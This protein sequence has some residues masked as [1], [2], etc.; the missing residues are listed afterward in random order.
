LATAF[1]LCA[2]AQ[3]LSL[4]EYELPASSTATSSASGGSAGNGGSSGHSSGDAGWGGAG[5][6]VDCTDRLPAQCTVPVPPLGGECPPDCG[7]CPGNKCVKTCDTGDPC[8]N[9]FVCPPGFACEVSCSSLGCTAL[10]V[11]CPE[12]YEC[13]VNC[14]WSDA[15]TGLTLKCSEGGPCELWCQGHEESCDTASVSCGCNSCAVGCET[16]LDITG[17]EPEVSCGT[18][19]ECES[20]DPPQ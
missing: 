5:G 6:A 3:L 18:S 20:C 1:T 12:D 11:V 16:N 15:C 4:D 10:T 9:T 19:C 7:G 13:R 17:Y 8:T 14:N 2:C